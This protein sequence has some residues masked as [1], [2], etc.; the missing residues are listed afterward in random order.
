MQ[1]DEAE[2]WGRR[3][4]TKKILAFVLLFVL[5]YSLPAAKALPKPQGFVNDFSGALDGG[6]RDKLESALR[7]ASQRGGPEIAVVLQDSTDGESIEDYAVRLGRAW[8]VGKKGKNDGLLFLLALKDRKLFIATG[9]GLEGD[10]PD[11]WI[12]RLRDEVITPRLKAGR[13]ED[14]LWLGCDALLKK[15][16][17]AGLVAGSPNPVGDEGIWGPVKMADR[18]GLMVLLSLLAA[19]LFILAAW[20]NWRVARA[21]RGRRGWGGG[22]GGWGGG[23]W[24]GG[25]FSG[26][27]GGFGGFGGGSFGGGGAGGSW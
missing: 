20:L 5:P 2:G 6:F 13:L 21:N 23:G 3:M 22:F 9:Y 16:G 1:K 10:L 18:S 12:G 4:L 7:A 27:G 11:G 14:A 26:G 8:G 25:G 15:K 17:D 19:P 24:G